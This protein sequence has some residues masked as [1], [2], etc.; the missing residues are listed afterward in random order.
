MLYDMQ[1]GQAV[2]AGYFGGYSAK[3]QDIGVK[4][5]QR[6]REARANVKIILQKTKSTPDGK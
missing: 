1:A 6:I 2:T 3:M 5:L 4:E